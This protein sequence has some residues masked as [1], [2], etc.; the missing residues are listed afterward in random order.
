MFDLFLVRSVFFRG[1][2]T[3]L[4][5][6]VCLFAVITGIIVF[7]KRVGAEPDPEWETEE[8][9][10]IGRNPGDGHPLWRTEL[11]TLRRVF[12]HFL[13]RDVS[14][15]GGCALVVLRFVMFCKINFF[16]F[17]HALICLLYIL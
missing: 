15:G 4:I 7:S 3:F 17:F 14:Y 10:I 16:F 13:R 2:R 1:V 9:L 5:S 6:F 11:F 8:S 12:E